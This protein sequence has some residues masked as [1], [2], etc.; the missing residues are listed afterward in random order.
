MNLLYCGDIN[1]LEG[2]IISLISL[3]N[4]QTRQL[5]VYVLTMDYEDN[6]KKYQVI[7]EEY[8]I[9]LDKI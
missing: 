5:F 6:N 2:L 9:K 8:I 4:H 1:V 7:P 3:A